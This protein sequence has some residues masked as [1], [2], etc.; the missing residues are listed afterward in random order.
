MLEH[1]NLFHRSLGET[2]EI[3]NKVSNFYKIFSNIINNKNIN[4][5]VLKI[6]NKVNV[7]YYE[8]ETDIGYLDFVLKNNK[9]TK[10]SI[11]Y[12]INNLGEKQSE[13]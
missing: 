9:N 5:N 8:F 10:T 2:S 7:L 6:L 12:G 13:A 4:N 3:V 1:E 11:N